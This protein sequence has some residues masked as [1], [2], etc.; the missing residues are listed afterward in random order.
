MLWFHDMEDLSQGYHGFAGALSE[1]GKGKQSTAY[2]V[3][4]RGT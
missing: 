2:T 4:R 1:V 3:V